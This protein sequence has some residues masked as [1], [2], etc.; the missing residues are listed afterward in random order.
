M[1]EENI[2]LNIEFNN[3]DIK[4]AVKNITDG[5]AAI[6]KLIESNKKLVEQGQKNSSN[7][8]QNEVAIKKLNQEV[9]NN[10]K[11]I[12]A[13]SQAVKANADSIEGLKQRNKEL[14][15][16][17]NLVST[18]TD[19]GR[20]KIQE[21]NAEYDKN[22]AVIA[23]NSTKVEQQR[24]NIG[25]YSS[26]LSGI[27]PQLGAFSSNLGTAS[28]ATGGVT[29]GIFSMVKASLAFV[30]TPLGAIIAALVVGFKLLQTFLTGSAAGMDLLEDVTESVSTVMNI[31]VDR[32]SKFVGAIGKLLSGDFSGGLDDIGSSFAGIGDEIERE[33]AL[34]L[35]LNKAIRA[36]ED[37]EIDYDIATS[38]TSNT[39][40]E[41]LA[42]SKNR[43]LSEQERIDLITKAANL[44]KKQTEDLIKI[45]GE[46][47]RIANEE[48]NKRIELTREAGET[49]VEFSKR[50]LANNLTNDEQKKTLRDVVVAYND[51]LGGSLAFQEKLQGQA[52]ALAEKAEAEADKRA[53]A[54]KKRLEDIQKKREELAARNLT[55]DNALV[56]ARL[57]AQA[58]E[59]TD[60]EAHAQ[61][62]IE[63]EK[64]KTDQILANDELTENER[65]LIRFESEEVIKDIRDNA[66]AERQKKNEDELKTAQAFEAEMLAEKLADYQE[67]VQ[68]LIN[69]EKQKLLDGVISQEEYNQEISDLELAALEVQQQLKEQFGEQDIA[70]SGR[71]T[72]AK[73]AQKQFEADQT[74]ALEKRKLDA[75]QSTLGQVAG[76]FNKNS[77]AFKA[78]ATA[79]TLIQTYQSAQ[80]V[81]TGMTSTIPGPVGIALGIA[82]AIAAIASGLA[83]VAKINSA[84]LPKLAEGGLIEIGGKRHSQGGERVT[85]GGRAVA[86]VEGGESMV[87]LKRGATP[88]LKNIANINRMAGGVD[89]Y[90]DRSPRIHLQDGGFIARSASSRSTSNIEASIASLSQEIAKI[91]IQVSVTDIQKAQADVNR[92]NV[93]SE[94]S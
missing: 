2:L 75:V 39:I 52:D 33:V 64:T 93:T 56:L 88:L 48:L 72:D 81:F 15:K 11:I 78:L 14:L 59:I 29:S 66:D 73:I 54:E 80:A 26:A 31:L 28:K 40:K 45:K 71:I 82:G 3:A 62:L 35:E 22:S 84:K 51:A 23:D 8:V 46:A 63:I 58:D 1:N 86:E 77:I 49:E 38:E 67:Y 36:L 19:E 90:N 83:N 34:T 92:A 50:L 79:Q 20:K 76:L 12:Q 37:A 47:L 53:E 61:K 91:K 18:A 89:F 69:A 41:L 17:R 94:L 24:F 57:Q 32:V 70:L 21:L 9:N 68:E 7:Y 85:I 30:A 5:R 4:A 43:T 65:Q 74:V 27:S 6:D 55:A 44:E 10:S 42:Q 60:I 16:E 13:N 25:N 87:I